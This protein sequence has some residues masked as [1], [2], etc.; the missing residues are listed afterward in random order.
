MDRAEASAMVANP[1]SGAKANGA[2]G[3]IYMD[4]AEISRWGS[5]SVLLDVLLSG[6]SRLGPGDGG[7][8][9]RRLAILAFHLFAANV[10][11][12]R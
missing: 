11:R 3:N 9:E 4:K 10:I 12:N 2:Q 7:N 8:A 6:G 5:E 1:S